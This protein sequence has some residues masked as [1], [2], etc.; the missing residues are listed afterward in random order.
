M[1]SILSSFHKVARVGELPPGTG[2][3]VDVN[4]TKIAL[5]NVDGRFHAIDDRCPHSGGSLGEGIL[6]G[7]VVTCP[8]HF[9]QFDVRRGC[10]PEFAD[11]RVDRFEVRVEGDEI[12]VC[13]TPIPE[14][15]A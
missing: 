1:E 7:C 9:W 12:S 2:R 14:S 8:Y 13:G 5:F 15:R 10:S 4:G 3:T 6:Q 11:A